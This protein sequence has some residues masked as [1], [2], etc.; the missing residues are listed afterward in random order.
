[1]SYKAHISQKREKKECHELSEKSHASKKKYKISQ[2]KT[3]SAEQDVY[4]RNNTELDSSLP[5][6]S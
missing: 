5:S 1:M 3:R 2:K 4:E 6:E